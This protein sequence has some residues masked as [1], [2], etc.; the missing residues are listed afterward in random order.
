M[1]PITKKQLAKKYLISY[2]TFNNWLSAIPDLN[3]RHRQRMLTPR[4]V[5]LIYKALGEPN[6]QP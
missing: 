4:Q 5:D 2:N 1:K 6:K 3:L